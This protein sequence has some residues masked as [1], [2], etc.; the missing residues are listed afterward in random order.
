MKTNKLCLTLVDPH[1]HYNP[2][3]VKKPHTSSRGIDNLG[4]IATCHYGAEYETGYSTSIETHTATTIDNAH[5][6][7]IDIPIDEPVDSS[8]EDWENDYYN[9]IMAVNNATPEIRDDLF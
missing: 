8:P 2:I 1:V 5:Q 6:K 4:L 3:P 7:S 9:P